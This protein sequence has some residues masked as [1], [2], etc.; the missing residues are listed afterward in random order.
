MSL[1]PDQVMVCLSSA[2]PNSDTL[3]RY[4]SRLAGRLN[5]N[6]YA[7]YVQTPSEE[8]TAIDAETQRVLAGTLTLAK[9]LGAM[10]FTYKGA[11]IPDTI[12]R[13]ARE[14]QVGHIVV[15]SPSR[16]SLWNKL[17]G[18]KSVVER[19]MEDAGGITVVVLD[20]HKMDA[21]TSLPSE[22][23]VRATVVTQP[24]PSLPMLTH[25]LSP[26]NIIIWDEP[27]LKEEV[28][29]ALAKAALSNS[30]QGRL[31]EAS[32]KIWER[33]Q[34]GSTFFN[35]GVAFPHARLDG[36]ASPRLALGLTR[37]GIVDVTTEQP[38]ESVFLIL[39]PA[40][41][42]T[43]QLQMLALTSKSAQN[44]HFLQRL[45]SA[46]TPDA[47]MKIIEDWER[48]REDIVP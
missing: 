2:G 1:T 3:L 14:Y 20:T 15:G 10:V 31:S 13:F 7:L 39:T 42:P 35:E 38:I 9:Q 28:L 48:M 21:K 24:T 4:A 40:Q 34:L 32:Q 25:F 27:V 5:R 46:P 12:L 45:R 11:D 6:W 18:R 8:P 47:A 33:E 44:R 41:S 29:N 22:P 16:L 43:A 19:L 17:R 37:H 26:G 30:E 23:P 36:L